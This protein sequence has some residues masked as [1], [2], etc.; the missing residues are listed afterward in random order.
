L[1]KDKWKIHLWIQK[2]I[3]K[4][5]KFLDVN[6]QETKESWIIELPKGYRPMCVATHDRVE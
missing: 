3:Y 5:G 6:V 2:D 4:N 1:K